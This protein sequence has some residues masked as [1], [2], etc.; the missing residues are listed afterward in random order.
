MIIDH[1][2]IVDIEFVEDNAWLQH[3]LCPL[4]RIYFSLVTYVHGL[5]MV[6]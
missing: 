4:H 1:D 2:G 3:D 6:M 5:Y